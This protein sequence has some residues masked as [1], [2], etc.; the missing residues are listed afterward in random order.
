MGTLIS[1]LGSESNLKSDDIK[2]GL[3]GLILCEQEISDTMMIGNNENPF[4]C[5]PVV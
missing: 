5:I 4:P 1:E 2:L 3:S